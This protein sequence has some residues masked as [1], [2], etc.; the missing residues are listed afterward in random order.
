MPR[1]ARAVVPDVPHHVTQRGNR[2]VDV[3]LDDGDRERY[4]SVVSHYARR[5]GADIWA[6]CLMTNHMHFVMLPHTPDSLARTLRDAQR[7]HANYLNEKLNQR[8]HL[9]HSRY[10]SCALDDA[11][12]WTAVRYVERNPVRA[13]L[14]ATAA[15]HPWSSAR[16]HC[17]LRLDPLL[18]LGFPLPG[19]VH[20]WAE[21][22][23]DASADAAALETLRTSTRNGRPCGTPSFVE[24]IESA[25]AR[26]LHPRKRGPKPKGESKSRGP[27]D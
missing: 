24:R 10:F 19:V 9:W 17:G 2:G 18:S 27:A 16:A 8:G 14:V 15:D 21:W 25:L 7:S 20:D 5:H 1:I 22:L 6:Y 12:L 11:H 4:L 23:A 13:G 3:F 26:I